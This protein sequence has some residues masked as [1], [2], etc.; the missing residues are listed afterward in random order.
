MASTKRFVL[1]LALCL[2]AKSVTAQ[3][4]TVAVADDSVDVAPGSHAQIALVFTNSGNATS[5]ETLL[6]MPV[7]GEPYTFAQ[8]SPGC[9]PIEPYLGGAWRQFSIDPI[10]AGGS[11]TCLVRVERPADALDNMFA[12][13]F[14]QDSNWLSFFIGTFTDLD[15]AMTPVGPPI[16][17]NGT[18]RATYQLTTRNLGAVGFTNG[19]IKLGEDCLTTPIDV[20]LD[21]PGACPLTE[22]SCPFGG[23]GPGTLVSLEAGASSSC[24][25]RY[26]APTNTDTHVDG[27]LMNGMFDSATGGWITDDNAANNAFRIDIAEGAVPPGQAPALSS[28]SMVL[29]VLALAAIACCARRRAR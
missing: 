20:E 9:G 4:V 6:V 14:V 24:L 8:E 2:A 12:D 16:L 22:L 26:R 15:V 25:V 11:R 1:A 7:H 28:W 18:V 21:F 17:A 27:G 23:T 13:W 10:P 19:L 29:L 3:D 5:P